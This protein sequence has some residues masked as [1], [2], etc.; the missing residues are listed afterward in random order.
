MQA[1][2][3]LGHEVR[4]V[5]PNQCLSKNRPWPRFRKETGGYFAERPVRR[6]VLGEL[7]DDRFDLAW[8]DGGHYVGGALVAG[9]K[10]RHCGLVVNYNVDDPFGPRDG[11]MW[12]IY[13]KALPQYD[14]VAVVRKENVAEAYA[15]GA[16]RVLHVLRSAD[17]VAH[18]PRRLDDPA[19]ARAASEVLF[20]GTYFPERGPF[21]VELLRLGVPLS[22]RGSHWQ[23]APEWPVLKRAWIGSETTN[24][25]DYAAS[26]QGAKVCLGLL[27]KGNRD[28]HTT[29]SMEIPMLG[30]LLC[31]ERTEEHEQLYRD[32][33]EA[34]F[35]SSPEECAEVCRRLLSDDARRR[36]IARAGRERC[37]R[38]G[39][40]NETILRRVL[41]E[42]LKG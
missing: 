17:E 22:I 23:R 26:I 18:A 33:E 5:D 19:I 24:D 8:V 41:D 35:W 25:E 28:L 9:L 11:R 1:M 15:L 6:W 20:L 42:A 12:R 10:A 39:T 36:A 7:G 14:L 40:Q 38:N 27:S 31:A 32:W 3:R 37:L 2:I 21:L 29:R 34:V 16:R 30:G 4:A 13:K